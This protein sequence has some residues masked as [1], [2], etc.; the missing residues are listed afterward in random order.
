MS[1]GKNQDWLEDAL[2]SAH[3]HVIDNDGFTQT[4]L[5]T[6]PPP[7]RS[8][9]LGILLGSAVCAG[10]VALFVLPGGRVLQSAFEETLAF[11]ASPLSVSLPL[12]PLVL[13]GATAWGAFSA[14]SAE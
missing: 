7:R 13:L 14:I 2:A 10:S 3:H 11:G 4:V 9:R 6:L 5:Q 1:H 12:V 8:W